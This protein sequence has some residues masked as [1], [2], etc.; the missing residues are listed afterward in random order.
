[1]MRSFK[2]LQNFVPKIFFPLFLALDC[3]LSGIGL[4]FFYKN[5]SYKNDTLFYNNA[6]Y[7]NNFSA[8]LNSQL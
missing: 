3:G 8:T 5:E 4:N 2:L 6:I 1:M 7:K